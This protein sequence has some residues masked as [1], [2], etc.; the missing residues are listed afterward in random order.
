M[1]L[2]IQADCD[3]TC[4]CTDLQ[5]RMLLDWF[6]CDVQQASRFNYTARLVSCEGS[7]SCHLKLKM[8]QQWIW[9]VFHCKIPIC[10]IESQDPSKLPAPFFVCQTSSSAQLPD[11]KWL[12][13]SIAAACFRYCSA[14]WG[15][16]TNPWHFVFLGRPGIAVEQVNIKSFVCKSTNLTAC[17][18]V[19]TTSHFG[20]AGLPLSSLQTGFSQKCLWEIFM[21][22]LN[23]HNWK[24]STLL[25]F[26][27]WLYRAKPTVSYHSHDKVG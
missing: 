24:E 26:H 22:R 15:C 16:C 13:T 2:C 9:K 7:C 8:W 18:L 1:L 3:G 21:C 12:C 20:C 4:R 23:K 17:K 14:T 19:Y 25:K 6:L 27:C 5:Q 11:L 10:K